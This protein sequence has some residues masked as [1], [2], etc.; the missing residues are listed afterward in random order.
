MKVINLI[1]DYFDTKEI[2]ER[3]RTDMVAV[4]IALIM[5]L[6]NC[7]ELETKQFAQ[8][9]GRIFLQLANEATDSNEVEFSKINFVQNVMNFYYFV[10][11]ECL[12][13]G[14]STKDLFS[15]NTEWN[16]NFQ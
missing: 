8:A 10:I 3:D 16:N 13:N 14:I 11:T 1:R 7:D 9:S 15:K 4:H 5:I 12:T 6:N 2:E